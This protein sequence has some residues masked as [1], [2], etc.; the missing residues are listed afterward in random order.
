MNDKKQGAVESILNRIQTKKEKQGKSSRQPVEYV[1]RAIG[2][3]MVMVPVYAETGSRPKMMPKTRGKQV[4]D[5]QITAHLSED[6]VLN[7]K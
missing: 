5:H 6:E 2:G 3:N 7:L 4:S 1:E